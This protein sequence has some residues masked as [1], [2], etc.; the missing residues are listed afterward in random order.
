M[1]WHR[2]FL[3][4]P[5]WVWSFPEKFQPQYDFK[6]EWW[7]YGGHVSDSHRQFSFHAVLFRFSGVGDKAD[8]SPSQQSQA[9]ASGSLSNG[10][11]GPA[12]HW[13]AQ[14]AIS[15]HETS[16]YLTGE[17]IVP[18]TPDVGDGKV[19]GLSCGNEECGLHLKIT[20]SA[21]VLQGERGVTQKA[22]GVGNASYHYSCPNSAVEGH[23]R[24]KDRVHRVVGKAWFDRE[25]M[26]DAFG[27]KPGDWT[28]A[29]ATLEDGTPLS[30]YWPGISISGPVNWDASWSLSGVPVK[31]SPL[32]E[33]AF[34]SKLT[35]P[36]QELPCRVECGDGRKGV[37]F[38]ERVSG[39]VC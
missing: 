13:I 7:W 36:Y 24:L 11:I 15:D 3:G 5:D 4:D 29:C 19:V 32:H 21:P 2:A 28:W 10:G 8:G 34:Q 16:E 18:N 38:I 12:S 23:L 39:A 35:L 9:S 26:S 31:L 1:K 25:V 14:W 17:T 20:L 27:G 33:Q 22:S 30:S 6:T 37:G